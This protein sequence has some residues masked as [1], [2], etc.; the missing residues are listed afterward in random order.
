MLGASI[1]ALDPARRLFTAPGIA[2]GSS[3]APAAGVDNDRCHVVA[4]A[5]ITNA[6]S[7][8]AQLARAGH[9]V[10]GTTT[11]ELILRCYE[12][13]GTRAFARLRGA[14]ACA[15]WDDTARR[16]ILAR[17]HVGRRPLYFALL[18]NH[19]VLF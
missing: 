13:W 3:G 10:R 8:R 7:L 6:S 16:L 14:F 2:L 15:I 12:A 19:G 1:D 17:D 18:P 11:S 4:D 9:A 5:H